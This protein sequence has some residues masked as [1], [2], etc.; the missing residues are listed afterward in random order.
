MDKLMADK[1]VK[2]RLVVRGFKEKVKVQLDL[3][4]GSKETVHMLLTVAETKGWRIK[5]GDVN[6]PIF[7]ASSWTGRCTWSHPSPSLTYLPAPSSSATPP[8][9]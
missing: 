7:M 6:S 4:T 9:P 2:A 3:S 8:V 5:N 1:K